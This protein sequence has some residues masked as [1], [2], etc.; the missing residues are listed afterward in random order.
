MVGDVIRHVIG[1]HLNIWCGIYNLV[2]PAQGGVLVVEKSL[3]HLQAE[4]D[5]LHGMSA[6][7]IVLAVIWILLI[8]YQPLY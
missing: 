7:T 3:A 2:A 8:L 4:Y 5:L 6:A 1:A